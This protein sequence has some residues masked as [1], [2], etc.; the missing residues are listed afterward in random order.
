MDR[1]F[2]FLVKAEV[3]FLG[4]YPACDKIVQGYGL[5]ESAVFLIKCSL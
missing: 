1:M 3:G 4:V 2:V 5:R